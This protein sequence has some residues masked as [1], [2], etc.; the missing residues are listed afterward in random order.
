MEIRVAVRRQ[1]FCRQNRKKYSCQQHHLKLM[2]QRSPVQ[3]PRNETDENEMAAFAAVPM[4]DE[5]IGVESLR[6]QLA[7]PAERE[8]LAATKWLRRQ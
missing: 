2:S 7:L 4:N 1:R 5:L 8:L 6:G 3:N